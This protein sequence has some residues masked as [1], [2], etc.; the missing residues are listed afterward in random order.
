MSNFALQGGVGI[1]GFISPMDTQDT[2]A[3]IDPLYGID[4][5][6]NVDTITD[7]NNITEERRRPG[8]I[9]G[10]SGGTVYYKL[11]N[12]ISWS[13]TLSDWSQINLSNIIFIDKETPT[14][15]IDGINKDFELLYE[16]IVGSEHIYL[17]G[18]LQEPGVGNDYVILGTT[19]T[20][21]LAPLPNMKILCSYR[22]D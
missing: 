19:I 21:E 3:V 10:V 5:L 7:L 12:I 14:G 13:Y 20:F 4:G 2:Y 22:T 15:S 8:M 17:N 11:K 6:R 1:L 16:P 18:L 9:V